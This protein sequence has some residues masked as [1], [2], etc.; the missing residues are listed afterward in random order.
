MLKMPA[1]AGAQHPIVRHELLLWRRFL[2]RWW[3]LAFIPI[4]F[5][6]L[7]ALCGVTSNL[8]IFIQLATVP[9]TPELGLVAGGFIVQSLYQSLWNLNTTVQWVIGVAIG[10][11]SAITIARERENRNWE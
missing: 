6:L 7:T 3:W 9:A 1:W 11:G 5:V 8:P 4:G 10:F 2:S